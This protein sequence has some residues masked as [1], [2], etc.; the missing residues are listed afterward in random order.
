MSRYTRAYTKEI[1]CQRC[2][3]KALAGLSNAKYCFECKDIVREERAR[4]RVRKK[5][6]KENDFEKHDLSVVNEDTE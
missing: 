4:N 3:K 5:P 2:G 1:T 6:V